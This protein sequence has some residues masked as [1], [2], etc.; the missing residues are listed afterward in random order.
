MPAI[1]IKKIRLHAIALPQV[2]PLR[3]SFGQE[4]FKSAVLIEVVTE[5]GV[6]GWGEVSAEIKPGYSPETM[7]TALH[8]LQEFLVP[9]LIGKSLTSP[10]EVP[11]LLRSVRGHH[12]AKHGLEAAVWDALAKAYDIRLADLFASYLPDGHASR[13]A[14]TVGVS[15]GI[16]PSIEATLA[17]IHKRLDQG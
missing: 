6:V 2:E 9:M 8:I 10:S 3:T 12:L 4:P 13:N 1:T 15:I 7:G 11:G 16:Q 17:I 5:E 14:A